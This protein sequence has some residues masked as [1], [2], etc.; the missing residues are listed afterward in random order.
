MMKEGFD[1]F[2]RFVESDFMDDIIAYKIRQAL[3]SV[4][5]AIH[6]YESE[7]QLSEQEEQDLK[8]CR[9]WKHSLRDVYAYFAG[10]SVRDDEEF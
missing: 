5:T 10:D 3:I 7:E 1:W 2:E 8:D 9:S 4:E 6:E